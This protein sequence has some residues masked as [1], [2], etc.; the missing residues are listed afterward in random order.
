MGSL[1]MLPD[2]PW[3]YITSHSLLSSTDT[4]PRVHHTKLTSL[5]NKLQEDD[6]KLAQ[7]IL[8]LYDQTNQMV[9]EANKLHMFHVL[10]EL[11]ATVQP[12]PPFRPTPKLTPPPIL[13]RYQ[14][15]ATAFALHE[16]VGPGQWPCHDVS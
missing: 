12:F 13:S 3:Q 8:T 6:T 16:R 7:A 1:H 4:L 14:F 2:P 9:K 15:A 11:T 10:K 5:C